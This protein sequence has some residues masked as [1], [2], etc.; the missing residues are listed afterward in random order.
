LVMVAISRTVSVGHSL[1]P[2]NQ[3]D[4]EAG[5]TP[6]LAASFF[7]LSLGRARS[8]AALSRSAT[9]DGSFLGPFMTP[10]QYRMTGEAPGRRLYTISIL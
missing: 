8:M 9:A 10:L 7:F 1:F 3:C 2:L 6:T 5:E 4:T